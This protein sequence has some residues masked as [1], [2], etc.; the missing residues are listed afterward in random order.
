MDIDPH[1]G[2]LHTVRCRRSCR[3]GLERRAARCKSACI[4]AYEREAHRL[5]LYPDGGA[6]ELRAAIMRN[7]DAHRLQRR[8]GRDHIALD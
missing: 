8:V 2:G 6:K 7:L 4:E 1:V 3:S 5:H